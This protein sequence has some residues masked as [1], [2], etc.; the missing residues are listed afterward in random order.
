M[1]GTGVNL[2]FEVCPL[3]EVYIA[4]FP[5]FA[6]GVRRKFHTAG[7][8]IILLQATKFES[9]QSLGTGL[10]VALIGSRWARAR[11]W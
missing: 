2:N 3:E 11:L 9:A 10:N 1:H 4:S 7:L 5:P 8:I 6:R